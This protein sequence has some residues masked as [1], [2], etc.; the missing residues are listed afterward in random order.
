MTGM[1][2][3]PPCIFSYNAGSDVGTDVLDDDED[4]E[5]EVDDDED[6]EDDEDDDEDGSGE[7]D[8]STGAVGAVNPSF[9]T[10]GTDGASKALVGVDVGADILDDDE[11]E[12]V[13]DDEDDED[14]DEDGSGEG[15]VST[16]AVGAVNPS[17]STSGT[18]GASKALVG[19]DV[20][21]DV[22]DVDENTAVGTM[23]D[24]AVTT[25]DAVGS[26]LAFR[27][28]IF[29]RISAFSTTKDSISNVLL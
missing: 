17:F 6:D 5:E 23:G 9:S 16:G 29:S 20:G 2:S 14:D 7:G 4:E 12:K 11:E 3:L 26:S 15:D 19:V 21:A 24:G 8:V 13:D 10:S 18:D 28:A 22:L 27:A 1:I 25:D